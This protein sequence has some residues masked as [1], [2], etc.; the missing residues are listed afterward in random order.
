MYVLHVIFLFLIALYF[1]LK[2]EKMDKNHD[3]LQVNC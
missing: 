3:I 2:T 1:F